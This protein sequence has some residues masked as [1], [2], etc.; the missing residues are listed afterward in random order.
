MPIAGTV[1]WFNN[2]KGYGFLGREGW[3]ERRVRAPLGHPRPRLQES[4][5]RR[6]GG[7]RRG[8]GAKGSGCRECD[9]SGRILDSPLREIQ[10]ADLGKTGSA[11]FSCGRW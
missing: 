7:V 9:Q 2:S 3:R 8:P 1:K 4:G 5:R 10:E 11:F 6:E